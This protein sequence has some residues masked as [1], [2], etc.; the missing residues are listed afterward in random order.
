MTAPHTMLITGTSRGIGRHLAEHYAEQGH[1]VVGCSRSEATFSSDHYEHFQLSVAD[2]VAVKKMFAA[3]RK[4]H[5]TLD[6]LI[7]N[8]AVA[9]MNH[10]LLTP[11]P[12]AQEI[13][14][15]NIAG[16]FLLCREAARIM[17]K[18]GAGRII[19]F[20]SASTVLQLEGEAVYAAS[21]A[22]VATLTQIMARELAAAGITVNAVGPGPID[23]DM[24][25]NIPADALRHVID[26]QAI[27]R[28]GT[29]ADIANVVDFLIRPESNFITGQVI[30]LGGV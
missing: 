1:Q 23:T 15:V 9:T 18:A 2:E 19:N 21:K 8:A 22:A 27:R 17:Q 25:K 30:Y 24:T 13:F 12:T 29:F 16:T 28:M 20:T 3:I 26:R 7:N 14:N 11:L 6:V 5:G 4:T 10:V